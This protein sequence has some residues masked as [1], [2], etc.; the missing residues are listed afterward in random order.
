MSGKQ[1]TVT[2][3]A[4]TLEII[5]EVACSY[6]ERDSV[7]GQYRLDADMLRY[8]TVRAIDEMNKREAR[9]DRRKPLL[10]LYDAYVSDADIAPGDVTIIEKAL[11]EPPVVKEDPYASH[12]P[13]FWVLD[14]KDQRPDE[15]PEN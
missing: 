4:K 11:S 10:S 1:Y 6:L 3:T 14:D 5:K 13:S 7:S 9:E 12:P 2:V 15:Q 8:R